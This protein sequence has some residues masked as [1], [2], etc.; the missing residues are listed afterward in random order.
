MNIKSTFLLGV[1]KLLE[2]VIAFSFYFIIARTF[3][4]AEFG[5]FSYFFSLASF[6]MVMFDF[7]GEIY[8][9]RL[10]SHNKGRDVLTQFLVIKTWVALLIVS[11]M[12]VLNQNHLFILL[13][14]MSYL[15]SVILVFRSRFLC[16]N[17][18]VQDTKFSILEKLISVGL[19]A[20]GVFS[21]ESLSYS[22][23]LLLM[24]KIFGLLV[25]NYYRPFMKAAFYQMFGL[26]K[27]FRFLVEIVKESWTYSLHGL[28]YL[29][30]YQLDIILLKMNHVHAEDIGEYSAAMKI[31]GFGLIVSE[32]LFRQFYP[33]LARL[34]NEN[35]V[36]QIR[37]LLRRLSNASLI[38]S[39]SLMCVLVVF[40]ELIIKSTFGSEFQSS[41]LI[42]AILACAMI[43]RFQAAPYSGLL[44][45]SNF[46][47][48]KMIVSGVCVAVNVVLNVI[49]IP[50]YG[51]LASAF[52][53]VLTELLFWIMLRISVKQNFPSFETPINLLHWVW[54]FVLTSIS[55]FSF[56]HDWRI[57][58]LVMLLVIVVVYNYRQFVLD[59][60]KKVNLTL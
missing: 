52:V 25:L 37:D 54:V 5:E 56:F 58:S 9:V 12:L 7:G 60:F 30:F 24:G 27:I 11:T 20:V 6:V 49:F 32:I 8:C 39:L 22:I 36:D 23:L 4:S 42:L 1:S 33:E 55:F 57:K 17:E 53:T 48:Y 50:K 16:F 26:R 41:G 47:Y 51:V 59:I 46:N 31:F 29:L 14:G 43:F 19:F 13:V 3:G 35:Q 28:T 2:K 45:A 44:A 38:I 10:F 34:L 21:F 18:I 40:S 15:D